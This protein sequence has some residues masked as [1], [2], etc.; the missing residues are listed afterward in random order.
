MDGTDEQSHPCGSPGRPAT[1]DARDVRGLL[2]QAATRA[3][4]ERGFHGASVRSIAESAGVNPAMIHY[5][6]GNKPGLY[7][8]V[9]ADALEPLLSRQRA[10]S[11]DPAGPDPVAEL[12]S[13]YADVA[14]EQPWLPRLIVR[15]I[16]AADGQARS[17]FVERIAPMVRATL[18]PRIEQSIRSGRLRGDLDPQLTTLSLV[19]LAVFPI[20]ATPILEAVLG[21]NADAAFYARLAEHNTRLFQEGAGAR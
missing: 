10:L 4:A 2:L 8:Q 6:F 9:L 12:F 14:R 18:P 7:A 5:Y 19:S 1:D 16:L 15:D 3:F 21:V 13:M 20:V 17:V 11:D